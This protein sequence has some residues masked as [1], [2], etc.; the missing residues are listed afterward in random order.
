MSTSQKVVVVTGAS[1]G[2]GAEVVK[3]FRKLGYGVVATARSIKPSDDPDILTVVGDIADPATARRVISEGV[4]RFGRIDTLVNNA[5]VFIA[6]PF[7]QYSPEDYATITG[8][9]LAGFFNITQLAIAE[10]EKNSSGHVVSVTTSLT[11]HAINGVPSVLASLTKG[12]IN[13]ATKSLAIEYAKKGIRANA[14]S[15]GIIKSPMHAPET[16]DALG[17]LHPMGHMG[18]MSDIVNAIVYLDSAAFVTGEILH[19]DGG[20]SAGH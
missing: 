13:S 15:P 20:Q 17:G 11:D 18:E 1:Q 8:V 12:G 3:A 16:H 14:V 19:V 4:A 7:T 5:G 10:M 6:K 2:I 9:N